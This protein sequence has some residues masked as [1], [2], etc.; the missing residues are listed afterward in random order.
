MD[1]SYNLSELLS[2]LKTEIRDWVEIRLKL[3]QLNVF[4][5]T[6]IVGSFLIFGVIIINLL[7]FAF[8]FAFIAL[9]VL[10]GNR[11]NSIAGGFAIICLLYLVILTGLL[12]F[13]KA[14]FTAFQNL[15][16]KELN[17]K[18]DEESSDPN[19]KS[20]EIEEVDPFGNSAKAESRFAD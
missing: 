8:L 18:P 11:I 1:S 14:V 2:A 15:L 6:A 16:L 7:L 17:P 4:E 19:E 3:L 13:R 10:I 12:I 9:G 20:Y 5:K